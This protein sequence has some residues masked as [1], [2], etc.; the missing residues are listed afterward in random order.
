MV[1]YG[2]LDFC[3]FSDIINS[4]DVYTTLDNIISTIE[5]MTKNLTTVVYADE[6][7]SQECSELTFSD[8]LYDY[9]YHPELRD[10]KRELSIQISK[11]TP[12][13]RALCIAYLQGVHELETS[14][15][16]IMSICCKEENILYV[17]IPSRYWEAKQWYLAGYVGKNDFLSEAVNCFPDLYFHNNVLSS[18]NTLNGDFMTERAIIVQHLHALGSFRERFTE[19][20]KES[21]GYREI[22]AEFE[23][24][25]AIEC[26]PQASRR[27]T[28]NLR[29]DFTNTQTATTETLCCE[30]HTKLKW[31][32]MDREHQD[33][34]YFHPGKDG[35]EDGKVLIVHIGTH[36]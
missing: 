18:F 27:A 25:Y 14:E 15:G 6:L 5:C 17:G 7:Y 36:Q 30:L 12:I 19:L 24:A 22:C 28:Q 23:S 34:I 32:G 11:A 13:D 8:W 21:V 33:R 2:V 1:S 10:I 20:R 26:S 4:S 9:T 35:I 31:Q 16:L 3:L 29:F